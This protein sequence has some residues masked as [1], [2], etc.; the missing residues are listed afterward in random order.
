MRRS[1]PEEVAHAT[2]ER[3]MGEVSPAG[4]EREKT[5]YG[6]RR[7]RIMRTTKESRFAVSRS[8][9]SFVD[10]GLVRGTR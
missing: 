3:P 4:A 6:A 7:G 1:A 5:R 9:R 8:R 2:D 10:A